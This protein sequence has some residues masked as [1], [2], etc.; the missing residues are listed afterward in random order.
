[1]KTKRYDFEDG[2]IV[3]VKGYKNAKQREMAI[4]ASNERA[5][6]FLAEY[7]YKTNKELA[8]EFGMPVWTVITYGKK[9]RLRKVFEHRGGHNKRSVA[10]VNLEGCLV[11]VFES[12]AEASNVLGYSQPTLSDTLRGKR[13]QMLTPGM[14]IVYR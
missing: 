1:M 3:D 4:D 12:L 13:K 7:P 2:W 6:L 8:R 14:T 9:Y 5:A 11:R 10:L